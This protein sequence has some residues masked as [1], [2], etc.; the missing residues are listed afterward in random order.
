MSVLPTGRAQVCRE[1]RSGVALLVFGALLDAAACAA[2]RLDATLVNMRFA[3]PLDQD[4]VAAVCA[5]HRALVTIEENAIA[6]GA[7]T[8]VAEVLASR[9]LRIPLLQLGIPDDFIEQGSRESCLAAARLDA[10]GL[11][12]SV[13]RWW[14]PRNP[15]RL[16]AAAGG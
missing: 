12:N 5:R 15:E 6:G 1:G 11:S 7:G 3:K 8:G 13:E 2:G 16:R 9:G 14:M 4:L 10:S